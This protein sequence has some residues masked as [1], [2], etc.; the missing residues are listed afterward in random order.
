M[1]SWSTITIFRGEELGLVLPGHP[2]R[3]LSDKF[4]Q[5]TYGC[6]PFILGMLWILSRFENIL[7]RIRQDIMQQPRTSTMLQSLP[8]LR[9]LNLSLITI[10]VSRQRELLM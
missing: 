9:E 10:L 5:W 7:M 2:E 8:R 3:E 1:A 6:L 4:G